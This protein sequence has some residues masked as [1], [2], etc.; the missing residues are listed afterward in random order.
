MLFPYS[1]E[2]SLRPSSIHP[3][4]CAPGTAPQSG[5]PAAGIAGIQYM[6]AKTIFSNPHLHLPR[7]TRDTG[8]HLAGAAVPASILDELGQVVF[9]TDRH[10]NWVFLNQAWQALSGYGV[11]ST[12]GASCLAQVHPDDLARAQSRLAQLLSGQRSR[13]RHQLRLLCADGDVRWIE[14][15]ARATHGADGA[16][17]GT[18]GTLSDISDRKLALQQRRLAESI[19]ASAGEGIIVTSA[20]GLIV[21]VNGAFEAITG[22][23]RAEVLGKNPRLLSS[24]RQDKAFYADM[25]RSI[26]QTGSWS[27]EVWNRRKSG[28]FYVERLTITGVRDDDGR[29]ACHVGV[30]ADITHQKLQAERLEHIAHYD[31]LTG[32]ANRRLLA[33]RLQQAMARARRSGAAVAVAFL[34][35]DDF[36]AINNVHGHGCGDELLA[37]L[38]RRIQ[39]TVRDSDTAC[40]PGGD[41]FVVV[42]DGLESPQACQPMVARL[43]HAISEP[44]SVGGALLRVSA[45]AGL[46]FYRHGEDIGAD[47]LI[48]QA[49]QAM[50]DAKVAGKNR[51]HVFDSLGYRVMLERAEEIEVLERALARQEFALHYQPIVH[52]GNG[53]LNSVE[54]LVRWNHPTRGCLPPGAF[55]PALEGHPL[56]LALENWVLEEALR[57]HL[58]W[59]DAG[60]D[61]AISVNMSGAQLRRKDFVA[62]LRGLLAAYPRV[63][64]RRIK[65]EVL[66]SSAL[67]DI[68]HVSSLV[69]Q[70]AEI[71]VGFALDDFGTG[72][73]SLRYLKQLPA[74]R[75]KIDQSFVRN[76]QQDPD[77]L[78]ILEGIIGM[79]AAFKREVVAE[80]V[81]AAEHAVML[82]QLGC[83][84]AQGY[85]IARPMPPEALAP[86]LATWRLPAEVAACTPLERDDALLLKALVEQRAWHAAPCDGASLS[87]VQ[88][89]DAWLDRHSRKHGRCKRLLRRALSRRDAFVAQAGLA[90][91]AG[92]RAQASQAFADALRELLHA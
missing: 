90:G 70:C 5:R 2:I 14:L 73:S 88:A 39:D 87:G 82:V 81:E 72:Y 52:L 62:H 28:E 11:A 71:G 69:T 26:G 54:A 8:I 20:E 1:N 43:L 77:D 12:L 6:L 24:G 48:R 80:G 29:L 23:A 34:D 65:L 50:Y 3:H 68:A 57:Q 66:E 40:R 46:A 67:D 41:E 84:L 21:D 25:W 61:V 64:P 32:L 63:D 45:S 89:F 74:R 16:V 91:P 47:Q 36:K 42:F 7:R 10:G 17:D 44:V 13:C 59:L 53:E 76:M 92:S 35:I 4:A 19:F 31:V 58:R 22:Y 33:D 79:A 78:A 60:L 9:Q 18:L 51:F 49:N 85:G 30:F 37:A 75:I 15:S 86:W 56:M 55:L 83:M 38:G 27:G